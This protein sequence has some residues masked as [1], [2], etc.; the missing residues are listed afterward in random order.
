MSS[1]LPA[2]DALSPAEEPAALPWLAS[3]EELGLA[4]ARR[5]TILIVEDDASTR[6]LLQACL[7]AEG[8]AVEQAVTA[9]T[10][11]TLVAHVEF[12]LIVLDLGL[13]DLDGIQLCRLLRAQQREVY[14]PIIMVT[15][16]TDEAQR[17]AGFAAGVDDYVTKPFRVAELR[18]R[19]RV[20]VQAH[21]RLKASQER[22]RREHQ[23][24][25]ASERQLRELLG[26][27]N[28]LLQEIHHRVKN[29]LALISTLVD[30][31]AA[32]VTDRQAAQAFLDIRR[33]IKAMALVH[34]ARYEPG[35]LPVIDIQ[36]YLRGLVTHLVA[37]QPRLGE[38][39]S[40][41]TALDRIAGPVDRAMLCGLL[42]GCM[43]QAS[44]AR[45]EETLELRLRTTEYGDATLV[46][47]AS[48]PRTALLLDPAAA[49]RV[50]RELIAALVQDLDGT[51]EPS[52]QPDREIR[53]RLN[54]QE[55]GTWRRPR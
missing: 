43:K 22:L 23:A 35:G 16:A 46:V 14:V 30:L 33:R 1:T 17:R 29:N 48:K 42:A 34:E 52:D 25:R 31:Q 37:S 8:Y 44:A 3:D 15:A 2:S 9:A 4:P 47:R 20:W 55:I 27:K 53:I 26:A 13:P 51:I 12:D 49:G 54:L 18:D 39:L 19:A 41:D 11:L 21:L 6:A 24:L 28:A 38:W 50:E 5:P 10:A 7:A 32:S 45:S 36:E 40:I